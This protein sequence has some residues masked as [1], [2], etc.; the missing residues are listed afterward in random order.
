MLR[1]LE[2][3]DPEELFSDIGPELRPLEPA[4]PDPGL[5][6][7]ETMRRVAV[8]AGR[9]RPPRLS[10]LGGG[11]YP[12]YVPAAVDA[13]MS[14]GEFFTSYTPYQPEVAQGG[15]Q[16]LWEYQSMIESLTGL[17]AA[18]ASL[19]DGAGAAAEAMLMCSY[20]RPGAEILVSRTVD[21]RLRA[22]LS[23]YAAARGLALKEIPF[24]DGA[25]SM[26]ALAGLLSPLSAGVI[27]QS[28]NYFG[29]V[30]DLSRAAV[31]VHA[32]GAFLVAVCTEALSLALLKSPGEAGAD[33]AAGEGASFGLGL[34][35]GGPGL[36]VIACRNELVRRLP[37]RIVGRTVDMEGRPGFVLTLQAREQHIRREAAL[38]NVC[39]NHSLCALA[40]SVYLAVLGREGLRRTAELNYRKAHYALEKISALP[41]APHGK[42]RKFQAAFTRPFFNEFAIRTPDASRL[43]RELEDGGIA[44]GL[45]LEPDYPELKDHFLVAVTETH[46]QGDIDTLVDALAGIC[47]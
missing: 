28:P 36:G 25:T 30:E 37:G 19:Y 21:P 10:F 16:A 8:L 47:E 5:S 35:Y 20:G 43:L 17:P 9:N 40:A 23:T 22:V 18:N 2:M 27:M 1:V 32:A 4:A 44:A 33:I 41:G 29:V 6:E 14:R 11:A 15:L 38:S 45:P 46:S 3:S 39:S 13:V 26:T 24:E 7:Q 12:H 42:G 34:S 31:P